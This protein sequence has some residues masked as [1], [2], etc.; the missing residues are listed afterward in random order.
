MLFLGYLYLP[1]AHVPQWHHPAYDLLLAL[2][3]CRGSRPKTWTWESTVMSIFSMTRRET[4]YGRCPGEGLGVRLRG[5]W[6]LGRR[7]RAR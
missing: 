2:V 4:Y 7:M 6:K 1:A 5:R 3:A